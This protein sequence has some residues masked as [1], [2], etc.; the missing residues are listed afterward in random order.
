MGDISVIGIGVSFG[1]CLSASELAN[2]FYEGKVVSRSAFDFSA[3]AKSEPVLHDQLIK[4]ALRDANE[5]LDN[6]TDVALILVSNNEFNDIAPSIN[7]DKKIS[8]VEKSFA[9]AVV[10]AGDILEDAKARAVIVSAGDVVKS[11]WN[12]GA[13]VLKAKECSKKDGNKV[14]AILKASHLE[15]CISN[16]EISSKVSDIS[17]AVLKSADLEA[18]Q[19]GYLEISGNS[20][21]SEDQSIVR[22]LLDAYSTSNAS[23]EVSLTCAIGSATSNIG[24][25]GNAATIA[26]FIRSCLSV[27]QRFIPAVVKWKGPKNIEDWKS[28]PFYVP[29][30]S[31]TWFDCKKEGR[32]SIVHCVESGSILSQFVLVEDLETKD[33]INGY[34]RYITPFCIPIAA[35]EPLGLVDQLKKLGSDL[36]GNNNLDVLAR[37]YFDKYL[38]EHADDEFALMVVG[39]DRES[40]Q[41]EVKFMTAGLP[42]AFEKK[43]SLKTPRGSYF[44]SKPLGSKAKVAFV[45][46]GA[47]SAYPGL[48]QDIFHM[49]PE[50]YDG[51]S[52]I[53][54]EIGKIV[55]E[56]IIYPRSVLPIDDDTMTDIGRK[57]RKKVNVIIESG[58]SMAMFYSM[59]LEHYFKLMPNMAFGYSVGEISMMVSLGVWTNPLEVR[60]NLQNSPFY[61][62]RLFGKSYAIRECWDIPNDK[63]LEDKIWESFTVKAEPDK[64]EDAIEN[65]T[66]VYLTLINTPTEVVIAGEPAAC[67]RVIEKLDCDYSRLHFDL[68]VHSPMAKADYNDFFNM[69]NITASPDVGVKFY[70]SGSYSEMVMNRE[71]IAHTITNCLCQKVD[72][73]QLVNT[74]YDD[75]ARVFIEIAPR[76]ICTR[77]IESILADREHLIVPI[78]I[79]GTEDHLTIMRALAQLFSHRIPIDLSPLYKQEPL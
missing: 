4:D 39:D 26:S 13:I 1:T 52:K 36:E 67:M 62:E 9:R 2:S 22:G 57:L 43:I 38:S 79:K 17:K 16:S 21:I 69:F 41:M 3:G 47:G 70:S 66:R 10:K 64:V 35:K 76:N 60:N 5:S 25:A 30:K 34:F 46:P 77:W 63:I 45:Y 40:L 15:E 33:R 32:T 18:S 71:E 59:I 6:L 42:N 31:R 48:G 75:G 55:K 23:E 7:F 54:P 58:V 12:G 19:I 56:E 50:V 37:D 24:D 28:A 53:L 68:A 78:N 49:F 44:T 20:L 8:S 73:P 61:N 27:Y 74:V 14:Y 51:V 72:F 29:S 65:E 11:S